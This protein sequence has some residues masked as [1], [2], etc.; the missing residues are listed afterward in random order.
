MAQ[1][2]QAIF[3]SVARF[4]VVAFLDISGPFW[5]RGPPY[6][7]VHTRLLGLWCITKATLLSSNDEGAP[8]PKEARG[9][10]HHEKPRRG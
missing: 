1:G 2:K 6:V 8:I 9:Q 3:F 4:C 5:E 7:R 10:R